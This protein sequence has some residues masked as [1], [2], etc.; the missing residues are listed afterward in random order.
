M[1]DDEWRYENN[2]VYF[3]LGLLFVG[4]LFGMGLAAYI[5]L[6]GGR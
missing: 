4:L 2:W 3:I 1:S 6:S 5:A